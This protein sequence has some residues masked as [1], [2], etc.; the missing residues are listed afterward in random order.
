MQLSASALFFALITGI[1][2]IWLYLWQSERQHTDYRV[3]EAR[4]ACE[5]ARFDTEFSSNFGKP[6]KAV[7]ERE[8]RACGEFDGQSGQ[9]AEAEAKAKKE[10]EQLKKSIEK[11]LMSEEAQAEL[12]KQQIQNAASAVGAVTGAAVD[13]ITKKGVSK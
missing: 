2:G 9:R 3:Q 11:S 1:L 5:K 6:S 10:G 8:K 12:Q 4:V 7:L 13:A